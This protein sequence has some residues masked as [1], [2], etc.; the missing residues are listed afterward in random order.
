M[1]VLP[2]PLRSYTYSFVKFK[3]LPFSL[4][5][6]L[7]T[8]SFPSSAADSI[9]GNNS[10]GQVHLTGGEYREIVGLGSTVTIGSTSENQIL[11]N[12]HV[13]L[14][15][16]IA[17]DVY[18]IANFQSAS[19]GSVITVQ[20]L[21]STVLIRNGST[22][23]P[24]SEIYGAIATADGS[25]STVHTLASGTTL[26]IYDSDLQGIVWGQLAQTYPMHADATLEA[27]NANVLLE[28][29]SLTGY[30]LG[31]AASGYITP[32]SA[33]Y[34]VTN[35]STTIRDTRITGDTPTGVVDGTVAVVGGYML[36]Y[37]AEGSGS[38]SSNSVSIEGDSDIHRRHSLR[39][40]RWQNRRC[41][42]GDRRRFRRQRRVHLQLRRFARR[43]GFEQSGPHGLRSHRIHRE[44]RDFGKRPRSRW[45]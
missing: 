29:S 42:G 11:S 40:H 8:V 26:S 1:F 45:I 14:D 44:H 2:P 37:L 21:D 32:A 18:G 39:D 5:W 16:V 23:D 33:Q 24:D 10:N 17:H 9:D 43:D 30:V 27:R 34:I 20:S 22:T 28:G 7:T 35:G 41:G 19:F 12:A 38:F 4:L 3:T 15:G 25:M 36:P 13:E 31:N 6:A